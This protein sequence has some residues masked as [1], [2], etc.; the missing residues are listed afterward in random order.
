MKQLKL[1]E[2]KIQTAF[3]GE[4][5]LGKRKC[6]RPLDSKRPLHLIFKAQTDE[7]LLTHQALIQV[8][9]ERIA[10]KNG[11]RIQSLVIHA[12]HIHI[13][14]EIP[15]R[16]IY[17]RWIRG[18]TGVLVRKIPG[19]SWKLLPYTQIVNWGRHLAGVHKYLEENRREAN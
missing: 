18:V 19:L 11:V 9:V 6:A 7:L 16:Q 13:I 14:L 5:N 4:L 12:D 17:N 3:G 2:F 15:Q 8:T 10:A 1:F